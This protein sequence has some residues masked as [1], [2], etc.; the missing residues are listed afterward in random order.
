[1]PRGR[2]D[3]GRP[4]PSSS[5]TASLDDVNMLLKAQRIEFVFEVGAVY[6][7]RCAVPWV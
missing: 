3:P 6:V 4:P 5:S 7:D 2:L 1:M